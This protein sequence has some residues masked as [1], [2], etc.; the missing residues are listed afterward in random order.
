MFFFME[1][2]SLMCVVAYNFIF[3]RTGSLSTYNFGIKHYVYISYMVLCSLIGCILQIRM[4]G[5]K[6]TTI[7]AMLRE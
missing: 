7:I 6:V 4:P 2:C 1:L 3:V 5:Y